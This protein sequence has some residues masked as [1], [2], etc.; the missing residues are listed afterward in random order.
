MNSM[1]IAQ[2]WLQSESDSKINSSMTQ[3]V[4][5]T[6]FSQILHCHSESGESSTALISYG[7]RKHFVENPWHISR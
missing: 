3:T 6:I 5:L 4:I 7:S 2:I 1:N